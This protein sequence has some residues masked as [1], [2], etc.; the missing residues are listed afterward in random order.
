MKDSLPLSVFS[1][2]HKLD[3]S[4]FERWDLTSS[5]L[6]E[7]VPDPLVGRLAVTSL[8]ALYSTSQSFIGYFNRILDLSTLEELLLGP[9]SYPACQSLRTLMESSPNLTYIGFGFE[10]NGENLIFEIA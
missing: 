6:V 7:I 2:I 5:Q 1:S 10:R 8:R 3:V 4:A 9:N